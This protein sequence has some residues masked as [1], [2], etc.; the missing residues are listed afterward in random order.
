MRKILLG[1]SC[2]ILTACFQTYDASRDDFVQCNEYRKIRN[3]YTS[4]SMDN[5]EFLIV[6][7]YPPHHKGIINATC[8]TC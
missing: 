5:S 4:G 3:L 1:I 8:M 7:L 6:P 2:L